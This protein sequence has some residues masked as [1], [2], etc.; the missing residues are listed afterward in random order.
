MPDFKTIDTGDVVCPHCGT[1]WCAD[2]PGFDPDWD[3]VK[4]GEHTCEECNGRFKFTVRKTVTCS[5]FKI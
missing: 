5:T 4:K 3:E 1:E 2:Q